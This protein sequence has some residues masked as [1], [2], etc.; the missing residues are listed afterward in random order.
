MRFVARDADGRGRADAELGEYIL[1]R[2]HQLGAFANQLVTALG[3]RRVDRAWN[4][5]YFAAL[6]ARPARGDQRA[7]RQRRL[8]DEHASRKAADKPVAARKIFLARRRARN[9]FGQDATGL[10]DAPRE[11]AV[12]CRINAIGARADDGE[13]RRVGPERAFVRGR[14]DAERQP[15]HNC[16][17]GRGKRFRKFARVRLALRRCVPAADD[18]QRR[19][20]E[21][22][23]PPDEED[24]RRRMPD[25]QQC[26][27]IV[28]VIPGDDVVL[29][30]VDPARR[31]LERVLVHGGKHGRRNVSR[32]MPRQLRRR[33]REYRARILE[34]AQQ[35][36]ERALRQR[37]VGE[38]C[39]LQRAR[40]ERHRITIGC[41]PR[42]KSRGDGD[43]AGDPSGSAVA[44][45]NLQWA[46][47][48]SLRCE[49]RR[50]N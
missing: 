28:G 5:E 17:V 43:A 38:R 29:R 8:D 16:Q 33:C 44:F 42:A 14:V 36:Y 35:R 50:S 48:R 25:V 12:A 49:L 10:R 30:I 39:P 24:H 37:L 22:R 20:V 21:Q 23:T 13:R 41:A 6:L 45:F 15:R 31:R 4:R 32:H 9:E 11:I 26:L 1:R 47:G 40:I 27:R 19:T 18:R 34:L 46:C 3:E 2:F 7:R